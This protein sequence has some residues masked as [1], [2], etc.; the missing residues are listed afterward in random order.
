MKRLK[1]GSI[2]VVLV[3]T[4]VALVAASQPWFTLRVPSAAGGSNDLTVSGAIAAP[5]LSALGFAALAL[6]AALAIAGPLIRIVLGILGVV[7]GGSIVL[8]ASVAL[9]D[10]VAA[11]AS[12][13]THATG[14]A[15]DSSVHD[16]VASTTATAWP[17]LAIVAGAL[18]A[19][20]CLAVIVTRAFMAG[21]LAALP[22]GATRGSGCARRARARRTA[23]ARP[24]RR[25]V[26]R[27]LPRR[28]PH[29]H[30][31]DFPRDAP[32]GEP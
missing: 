18:L 25:R 15:G 8:A 3:A 30:P 27:A 20:T 1:Y 10:P 2:V 28:R 23:R 7:L 19:L 17:V 24:R 4:A 29:G 11:G 22:G 26:G 9:S 21:L 32:K 5:A 6:V 12:V 13:V 31:I 14:V 16:L